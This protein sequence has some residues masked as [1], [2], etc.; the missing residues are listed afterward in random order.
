LKLKYKEALGK[1]SVPAR[2]R[3]FENNY[4]I[5]IGV[6]RKNFAQSM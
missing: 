1:L 2:L 5:P 4:I 3:T 6:A